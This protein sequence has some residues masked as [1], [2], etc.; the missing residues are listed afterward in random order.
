VGNLTAWYRSRGAR[1]AARTAS[2]SPRS[3]APALFGGGRRASSRVD[4]GVDWA[5]PSAGE[6]AW[7]E[8]VGLGDVGDI[9]S[10]P[11]GAARNYGSPA[12][13]AWRDLVTEMAGTMPVEWLL[14]WIAYESGGYP[15]EL[16]YLG[17]AGIYQ[18]MPGDNMTVAG[19][20]P[21]LQHP[22][23]PCAAGTGGHTV[24]RA[25]LTDDQ[26]REQVRAGLAYADYCR[27]RARALLDKF[28]YDWP[29][30]DWSFWALAKQ[31][32]N[33]PGAIPAMLQ[34]GIDGNAGTPPSDWPTMM[35]YATANATTNNAQIVG[36][37]GQ[38][39]GSLF[40]PLRDPV[41]VLTLAAFGVA[42]YF[43]W[44]RVA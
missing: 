17:E 3:S 15:C 21:A 26:A 7:Y 4:G 11:Y 33:L 25:D 5:S 31:V 29:E 8:H 39:G 22:V 36:Q 19:T 43:I 32:F 16:T 28:G 24:T 18:L 9:Q 20:T 34:A 2:R 6:N 42:A 27:K 41:T 38:G 44:K 12:V 30:S 37:Y 13:E 10:L 23:P 1:P 40:G 14:A 35:R